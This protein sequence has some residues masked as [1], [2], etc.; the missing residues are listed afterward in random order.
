MGFAKTTLY[1][2]RATRL[3]MT[4]R[5]CAMSCDGGA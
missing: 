5:G 4:Q 2:H 1:K 3:Y